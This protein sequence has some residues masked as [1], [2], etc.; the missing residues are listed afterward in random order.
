MMIRTIHL[1]SA[2]LALSLPGS[3]RSFAATIA[4]PDTAPVAA[5]ALQ[6]NDVVTK[7]AVAGA[8]GRVGRAVVSELLDRGVTDVVALVRD[9]TAAEALFEDAPQALTITKC[10]LSNKRELKKGNYIDKV[11]IY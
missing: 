6:P 8:T 11:L 5:A 7:V 10:N 3:A 1:F 4:A 2:L 9:T